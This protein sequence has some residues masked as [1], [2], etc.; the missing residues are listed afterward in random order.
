MNASAATPPREEKRELIV[1]ADGVAR[2]AAV[3]CGPDELGCLGQWAV[4]VVATLAISATSG[5]LLGMLAGAVAGVL[6]K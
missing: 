5:I 4:T 1:G 6:R 2:C 3:A